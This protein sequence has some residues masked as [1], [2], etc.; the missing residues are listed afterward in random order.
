MLVKENYRAL[1]KEVLEQEGT[2]F[3]LGKY[4]EVGDVIE[5]R[6]HSCGNIIANICYYF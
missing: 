6:N 4:D 5:K 1:V 3:A 2:R